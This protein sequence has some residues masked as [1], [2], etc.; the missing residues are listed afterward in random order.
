MADNTRLTDQQRKLVE[1]NVAL[2]RFLAKK[3]WDMSP[4]KLDYEDLVS[5]AYQGLVAAAQKFDP[6][7]PDIDPD[8]LV[9]GK[10]FSGFARQKIIGAIL[11]WQKKDADHVPRSYRTD[12]RILQRLGYPDRVKSFPELADLADLTVDRVKMVIA[13]V[14]RAPVSFDELSSSA[15]VGGNDVLPSDANVEESVLVT[16]VG[17]AVSEAVSKMP[18]LQQVIIA[19]RYFSGVEFQVIAAEL[20]VSPTVIREAH[21]SAI[22]AV[23]DA[24][25]S[26]V[27][28]S[29]DKESV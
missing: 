24:M 7:R 22:V 19:L 11:D 2:A 9:N 28:N 15:D 27:E 5:L 26:V 4:S 25:L 12:Y 23:Y 6:S 18:E 14:E 17:S 29:E 10:A 3:R 21:S 16:A 13:A 20:G 8:D 1:D